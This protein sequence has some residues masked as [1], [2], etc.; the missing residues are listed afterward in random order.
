LRVDDMFAADEVIVSRVPRTD[1]LANQGV[2]VRLNGT[3]SMGIAR[4]C[5]RLLHTAG[6][7]AAASALGAECDVVRARLDAGLVDL[8]ALN[9]ARADAAQLAV[10]A[11]AALVVAGG[12]PSLRVDAQAQRLARE[13]L[14]VLVAA[15]RAEVKRLLLDD[16]STPT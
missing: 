1:F 15:S 2:P 5:V 16:L 4:R 3:L 10:R 7:T 8:A 6:A 11:G 9:T 12:G 14:F 13:A